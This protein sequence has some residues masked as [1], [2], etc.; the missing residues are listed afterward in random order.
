LEFEG[1]K[2]LAKPMV[3]LVSFLVLGKTHTPQT[4]VYYQPSPAQLR[5]IKMLKQEIR[6]EELVLNYEK[7]DELNL[8]KK[9]KP[10]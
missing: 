2:L 9:L 8:N 3:V 5:L 10:S 1:D 4:N 7:F 6:A